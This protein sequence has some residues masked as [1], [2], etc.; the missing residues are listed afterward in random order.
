MSEPKTLTE[1]IEDAVD[2]GATSVEQI[3]RQIAELP[4]SALERAGLFLRTVGDVRSLQDASIGA[5]YDVIRNVNHE[6]T[7]LAKGGVFVNVGCAVTGPEVL[8]K[9]VS[10]AGNVGQPPMGLI[11]ADFDL[12]SYHR[13]AMTNES[14]MDYYFR[15]HKSIIT[16]V[17]EAFGGAG[18]YVQGDQRQ[19]IPRR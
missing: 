5:V 13:D 2:Q 19:T 8:L 14:V 10:M 18:Y 4:L 17:P 12:K 6:V 9:A 11:T 16:R 7:K 1:L 15:H 3:H